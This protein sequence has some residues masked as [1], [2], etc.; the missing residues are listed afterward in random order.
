METTHTY[1][2]FNTEYSVNVIGFVLVWYMSVVAS[3][4]FQRYMWNS[5]EH[6]LINHSFKFFLY[7]SY[8]FEKE[9]T[10]I[11]I[12]DHRYNEYVN[13]RYTYFK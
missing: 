1:L 6:H 13:V 2:P 12:F 10:W 3:E 4:Q 7:V 8:I 9:K 5:K 11:N